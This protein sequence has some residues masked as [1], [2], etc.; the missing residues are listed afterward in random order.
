MKI[1][2]AL[3]LMILSISAVR[4]DHAEPTIEVNVNEQ[5][6]LFE[7]SMDNYGEF[8]SKITGEQEAA[9]KGAASED[10]LGFLTNKSKE[11]LEAA[12]A[13]LSDIRAIDLNSQGSEAMNKEGT[14]NDLYIDY[15]KPL[16]KQHLIDAEKLAAGQDKLMGNLLGKLQEIGVDCKTVKGPKEM[17]PTFY[18]QVEQ[19]QHKDTKYN[20][21]LCEQ[22]RSKYHCTDSLDLKCMKRGMKWEK[23]ERKEFLLDG[24]WV[25]AAMR[26][27]VY[28]EKMRKKKFTC[29][30]RHAGHGNPNA[31][32]RAY[33]ISQLKVDA[34]QIREDI[35][36]HIRG[37]GHE[38]WVGS[39][40]CI[41]DKFRVVYF[42][43]DGHEICE[44]WK[45][46]W[47]E[48]CRLK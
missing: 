19:S 1:V 30:I 26:G 33:I 16:N 42:F 43:R 24:R 3:I 29:F 2:F 13:G 18:L 48:R 8:K 22:P 6:N 35:H 45:E 23:W 7:E 38:H 47:T 46:N 44:D 36:V 39:K 4:A 11:E 27:W 25:Y 12:A 34:R 15:S 21:T 20:K 32:I 10:G 41:R 17:E 31:S 28:G 40:V 14:M 9:V 5:T 37:E